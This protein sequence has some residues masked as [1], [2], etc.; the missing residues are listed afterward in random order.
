VQVKEDEDQKSHALLSLNRIQGFGIFRPK[1][2]E[3]SN[4]NDDGSGWT[5]RKQFRIDNAN[6]PTTP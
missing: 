3:G 2:G 5:A 6:M 4:P 1:K